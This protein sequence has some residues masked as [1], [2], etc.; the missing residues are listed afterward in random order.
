[1]DYNHR[2]FR[3]C[4]AKEVEEIE[5]TPVK[6]NLEGVDLMKVKETIINFL[7]QILPGKNSPSTSC[8]CPRFADCPPEALVCAGVRHTLFSLPLYLLLKYII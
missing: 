6:L 8:Y 7:N 4:V 5:E 3:V 1:M 2:F